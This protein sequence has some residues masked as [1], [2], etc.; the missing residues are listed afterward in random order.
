M[1]VPT[2]T[3]TPHTEELHDNEGSQEDGDPNTDVVLMPADYHHDEGQT[4]EERYDRHVFPSWQ[5]DLPVT[6]RDAGGGDF[7]RKSEQPA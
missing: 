3:V 6:D 7:E 5:K 4:W 1:R 2:F